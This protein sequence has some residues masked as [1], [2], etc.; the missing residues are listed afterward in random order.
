MQVTHALPLQDEPQQQQASEQV[1]EEE[2]PQ[3][4]E[5]A[6]KGSEEH[7][8]LQSILRPR[9]QADLDK[10]IKISEKQKLCSTTYKKPYMRFLRRFAAKKV[11]TTHP[12]LV[13][14]FNDKA[15]RGQLFQ[16]FVASG[17]DLESC[18]L[19]RKRRVVHQKEALMSLKPYTWQD[20]LDKYRGDE[21]YCTLI[22]QEAHKRNRVE[23]DRLCPNDE[24]K[25]KYWI[26]AEEVPI[27]KKY[28]H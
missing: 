22:T 8:P 13:E 5:A 6:E 18:D 11:T 26:V 2:H 9:S 15:K 21:E 12:E 17:E 23:K 3:Q 10:A 16:D 28:M 25:M 14:R 4:Q 27:K 1:P 24:S 19:M 7:P 20:L